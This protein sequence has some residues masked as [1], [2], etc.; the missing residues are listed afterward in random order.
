MVRGSVGCRYHLP[1]LN[2]VLEDPASLPGLRDVEAGEKI[3][4]LQKVALKGLSALRQPLQMQ[5]PMW[6][7]S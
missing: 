5:N 3:S 2:S 1:K 7:G 4:A 6:W